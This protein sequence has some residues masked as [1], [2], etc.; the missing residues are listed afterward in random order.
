[1]TTHDQVGAHSPQI[2]GAV[3]LIDRTTDT[4]PIGP[5]QEGLWVFWQLNP[6]SAAYNLPET[7][8]VEGEF[9][10]D[11]IRFAFDETVRR[12]EALRT[13]FHE[14]ESGVV[15]VVSSDPG[16]L[17][18]TVTDLRDVPAAEHADR[19]A[20][21]LYDEANAPFDLA[22]DLPIRLAVIRVAEERTSLLITTHHIACDGPSLSRVLEDFEAFHQAAR[23]GTLPDLP[24]APPGYTELV[25]QQLAALAGQGLRDEL[26]YWRDRLA[27]ARGSVLPGDGGSRSTEGTHR[28]SSVS[29]VLQPELA[30]EVLDY[31][32]RSRATPFTV[33]LCTMQIMIAHASKD[34]EVVLGT[35]TEGRSRRFVDTVGM[36][37]NTL[38]IK[39]TI[40]TSASFAAVL[41]AVSLD[42]MDALDY[43]DLPYSRAIAELDGSGRGSGDDL[44]K[45][46]FTAGAKGGSAARSER[47]SGVPAYRVEGPFDVITWTYIEG[48]VVVLDWEF[49]LRSYSRETA[50]GYRDAYQEI[51]AALV[52]DP[53]APIDSLGLTDV[54]TRFV[55][56][57]SPTT[58][59]GSA[60]SVASDAGTADGADDTTLSP[61]ETAVAAIWAEFLEVPVESPFDDFFQLG[62]HSMVASRV[63]AV[64]RR[65]V[66]PVTM[67]K[68]FDHPRLRD[69]CALLDTGG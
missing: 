68:L 26:D 48:S 2:E 28:T 23:R 12:H 63:V 43:Q 22:A 33:L 20:A 30:A 64:V 42:V 57:A 62:G 35:A 56:D 59:A 29:T 67:R 3:P 32:R 69:F 5:L 18:V 51:L 39:S 27:G 54:L 31:A 61:V 19:L 65:K 16:P 11:A 45:T 60:E 21:T 41:E 49:A 8:H 7:L 10:L 37:V 4:L 17:P 24:P 15:Q 14:T 50:A 34:R 6:A 58:V 53:E 47:E 55:P 52:R 38:V 36:L 13:T 40:D 9:D 1:M 46:M 25:R 44:I 66:A